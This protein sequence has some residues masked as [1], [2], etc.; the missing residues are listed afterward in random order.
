M[1]AMPE[2]QNH[3]LL[4]LDQFIDAG[5]IETEFVGQPDQPQKLRRE[6]AHSTL[7]PSAAQHIAK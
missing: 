2:R 1:Q 4:R 3:R 6:K 7:N 5:G